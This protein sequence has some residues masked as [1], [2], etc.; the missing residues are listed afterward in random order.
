MSNG[1]QW[2]DLQKV[3]LQ[4]Q[5][6]VLAWQIKLWKTVQAVYMPQVSGFLL[7]EQLLLPSNLSQDNQSL[8]HKG[9]VETENTLCLAQVQDNLVDLRHLRRTLQSLKTYFKSNVIG[10]GPKTQTKSRA[11][12]SGVTIQT[13][14]AVR[15]YCLAYSALLSLDPDSDWHKEYVIT[16]AFS[17]HFTTFCST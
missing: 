9:V 14:Q 1:T 15:C 5:R 8:C 11:I 6:N 12:K 17:L 13:N 7:G 10:E 3:E 4:E 2:T 16:L